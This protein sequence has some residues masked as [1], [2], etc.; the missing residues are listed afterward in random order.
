LTALRGKIF[1]R[2][3]DLL[4]RYDSI[5]KDYHRPSAGSQPHRFDAGDDSARVASLGQMR[6][7]TQL[8]DSL[9]VRRTRD[10]GEVLNYLTDDKQHRAAVELLNE[11][12]R[13]FTDKLPKCPAPVAAD[14]RAGNRRLIGPAAGG[15]A[16]ASGLLEIV[17]RRL[18][19]DG[20]A[21]RWPACALGVLVSWR[22]RSASA[23]PSRAA[24]KGR[25]PR[26]GERLVGR[27]VVRHAAE[28]FCGL[29]TRACPPEHRLRSHGSFEGVIA[30]DGEQA[31]PDGDAS[32]IVAGRWRL[33]RLSAVLITGRAGN[34]PR[35]A[36]ARCQVGRV[37]RGAPVP[38]TYARMRAHARRPCPLHPHRPGSHSSAHSSRCFELEPE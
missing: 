38:P 9:S 20:R 21:R 8:I 1:E 22:C 34:P 13:D 19:W 3:A 28:S 24:A 11:Q 15:A 6:T 14:E 33:A 16:S 23:R 5:R 12:D 37:A 18:S 27:V 17:E 2:N 10:V 30:G 26:S 32:A 36:P 29:F 4:A 31:R 35:R 25:T 7:L